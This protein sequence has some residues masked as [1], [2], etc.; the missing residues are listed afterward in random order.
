LTTV[1]DTIP[2][3]LSTFI[4]P[5]EFIFPSLFTKTPIQGFYPRLL[6]KF[7]TQFKFE[8]IQN[9]LHEAIQRFGRESLFRICIGRKR[10]GE[11]H[12]LLAFRD[13]TATIY[14]E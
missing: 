7:D 8:I 14:V 9:F 11:R 3:G 4:N 1:E 13:L 2:D 5:K 12:T 6:T 10:Q